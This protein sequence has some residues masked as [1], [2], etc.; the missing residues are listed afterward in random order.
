MN[1]APEPECDVLVVGAGLAG[2]RCAAMLAAHGRSVEVWEAGERVGGRVRT[3]LIDGYRCDRGFQVLNP[4]YPELRKAVDLTALGL[5]AFEP[6]IAIRRDTDAIRWT[7][8][9]RAPTRIPEMLRHGGLS[10]R[11]VIALARWAAPAIRPRALTAGRGDIALVDALERAGVDGLPRRVVQRFLA[12]V[13]LEDDGSTSNA[14]VLLLARMFALGTPGLPEDGM[15]ALPNLL[16]AALKDRIV[17]QRRVTQITRRG[18][19]WVVS[20]DGHRVCARHVVVATD[21]MSAAALTGL[22][23]PTMRGVVTDWW[24][25]DEPPPGPAMLWVDGRATP[26]GPVLNCAAISSAAPSYAPAG[27]HLIAASALLSAAGEPPAEAMM[28]AHAGD[29]LAAASVSRW[30]PVARHVVADALPAQPAPLRVRQPIRT[31]E[32]LWVCGD[33]RDTASIQGALVSGRR[34]GAAI[35][36]LTVKDFG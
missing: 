13:V 10:T 1:A 33:H 5:Q 15:Q 28:R 14:F 23:A 21:P 6:G 9:L 27:R 22:P 26:P 17:L 30:Q 36:K 24:A 34:V 25:T 18:S 8:P 19:G 12:G 20:S 32:G 3:D 2:L 4:A 11:E 35:A 16:A 31:G 29:I 7:H